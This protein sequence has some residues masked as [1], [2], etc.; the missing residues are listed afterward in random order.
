MTFVLNKFE[1]LRKDNKCNSM[2]PEQDQIIAIASVVEKL[3]DD[4]LELF[5]SFKSSPPGKG[6]VK[7][8][9]QGKKPPGKQ[10][11]CGKGKE[12]WKKQEP[13]DGEANTNKVNNNT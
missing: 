4:N 6:K 12:E 2:S 1:I 7:G 9:F 8:K 13:K 10:S 3:K 11:Q 5:N